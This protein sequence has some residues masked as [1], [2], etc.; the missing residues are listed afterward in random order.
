MNFGQ[1]LEVKM[2][3]PN[4]KK[5]K[6]LANWVAPCFGGLMLGNA[7]QEFLCGNLIGILPLIIGI[8]L[9]LSWIFSEKLFGKSQNTKSIG[10]K[11]NAK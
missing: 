1:S 8:L 4:D 5:R 10:I 3:S 2:I 7:T 11:N 9:T 6:W